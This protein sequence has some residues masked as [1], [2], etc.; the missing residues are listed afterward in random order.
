MNRKS[1]FTIAFAIGCL[2]AIAA[3]AAA[4]TFGGEVFGAYSTHSMKDWNDRVVTPANQAGGNMDEFSNGYGG[5]LGVRMWPNSSWMVSASWEPLFLSREEKVS[6]D[7]ARLDANAFEATA[8][9]FFPSSTQARFGLGAGLGI[10]SLGGEITSTSTTDVK[11]EGS[12][13]GFHFMGL[14]EWNV[15]PGF[16]VTGNAGYRVANIKDTQVDNQSATPELAT[17]YSGVM[18]RAGV[19][20]YLPRAGQ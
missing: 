16:A 18:L 5:G 2:T 7:V 10:Y 11:L 3:P 8:G 19:A 20:F 1:A 14:M 12:T 4:A 17:D 9:Y 13:V 6:G 15:R